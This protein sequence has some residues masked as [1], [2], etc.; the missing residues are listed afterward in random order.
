[1][2]EIEKQQSFPVM[3]RGG[4]MKLRNSVKGFSANPWLIPIVTHV[5]VALSV[6]LAVNSFHGAGLTPRYDLLNTKTR[7]KVYCKCEAEQVNAS[8][9]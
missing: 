7:A 1:M 2:L 6:L 9:G 4:L 5:F 3:K 8:C